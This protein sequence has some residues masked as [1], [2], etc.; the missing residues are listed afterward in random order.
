M[1]AF[2][3]SQVH[4]YHSGAHLNLMDFWKAF[5][6]FVVLYIVL[7]WGLAHRVLYD[8]VDGRDGGGDG[9]VDEDDDIQVT[10]VHSCHC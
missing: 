4:H 7:I 9:D 8:R 2:Y 10:S 1:L 5:P 6:A 3:I